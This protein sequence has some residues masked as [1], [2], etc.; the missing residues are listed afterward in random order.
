VVDNFWIASEL[1]EFIDHGAGTEIVI[2][3]ER[4]V[5]RADGDWDESDVK[6]EK[7]WWKIW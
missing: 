5:R 4:A 3:N 1:V 6:S 7:P 2:G